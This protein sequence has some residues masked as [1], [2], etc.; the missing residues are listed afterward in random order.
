MRERYRFAVFG[1][2]VMPKHVHLLVSEP[3]VDNPSWCKP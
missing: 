1:Y 2:V 3:Q